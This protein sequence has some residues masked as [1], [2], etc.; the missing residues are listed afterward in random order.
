MQSEDFNVMSN[1]M[2]S[3]AQVRCADGTLSHRSQIYAP[4]CR[5]LKYPCATTV[6]GWGKYRCKPSPVPAAP[7]GP[8]GARSSYQHL[9]LTGSAHTSQFGEVCGVL[10]C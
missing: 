3:A 2:I 7:R 1:I 5:Q 6:D 4:S 8:A 10:G 9:I